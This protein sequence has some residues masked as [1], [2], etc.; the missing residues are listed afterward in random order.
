MKKR[1]VYFDVLKVITCFM[2]IMVHVISRNWYV[3]DLK[4]NEFI[5]LTILDSICRCAVPIY[6]MIS[7]A[8]FL[9]EDKDMK[10]KDIFKKYILNIFL[11]Y[12]FWNMIYSVLSVLVYG[13]KLINVKVIKDIFVSTILG[14]GVFHLKFLVT[15]LGFYLCVPFIRCITK[16][17]NKNLLQYLIVLLFIFTCTPSI[18]TV[19]NINLKYPIL[20]TG[21]TLYFILGYYLNTFEMNKKCRYIIYALGL[22]SLIITPILTINYSNLNSIHSQRFFEY[23]SFNIYLYSA[24][25]FLLFKNIFNKKEETKVLNGLSKLYFGVYLIHGLV[26]GLLMKLNVFG[27]NMN[28]NIKTIIISCFVFIISLIVSFVLSKIPFVKRLI[29]VK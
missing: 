23:G 28:L 9:N 13:N 26:L 17:E 12:L 11:I 24:S 29:Y 1:I 3:L 18:L 4:S 14:N 25:L 5:F 19:F 16:K 7:G 21:F 20:F 2:V 22:I 27:L 8:I 15:I 10:I 6:L